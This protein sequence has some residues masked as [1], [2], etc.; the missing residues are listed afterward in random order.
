M[1]FRRRVNGKLG[2]PDDAIEW[3]LAF[4]AKRREEA[5]AAE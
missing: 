4:K 5:A 1:N 2:S 3:M